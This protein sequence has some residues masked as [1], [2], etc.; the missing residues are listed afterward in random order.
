[1]VSL[2][3][4]FETRLVH[5]QYRA[6]LL[7]K[8]EGNGNVKE[9][10]FGKESESAYEIVSHTRS[11]EHGWLTTVNLSPHTGRKHQ[12]RQHMKH[13]GHPIMGDDKYGGHTKGSG[14]D[15]VGK[16]QDPTL[17][18]LWAVKLEVPM[19]NGESKIFQID[20]PDMYTIRRG[21]H[22][23]QWDTAQSRKT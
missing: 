17:L 19:L 14:E 23:L 10:V 8:L 1:V 9:P 18:F 16:K 15:S 5:K 13:L 7:G 4:A 6:L 2:G 12:L 21:W 20:E 3:K 22:Q 11:L